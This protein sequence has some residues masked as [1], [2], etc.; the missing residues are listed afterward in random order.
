MAGPIIISASSTA[1]G[2]A[3]PL[4]RRT[5]AK[6]L[7]PAAVYAVT[8]A[9]TDAEA[10]RHLTIG[11]LTDD[12]ADPAAYAGHH[13]YVATGVEAGHQTR[14]LSTGTRGP[15]GLIQLARPTATVVAAGSEIE[16]SAAMP[17]AAYGTWPTLNECVNEAL[18][19]LPL[20]ID[21]DLTWVAAQVRYDLS[22]LA[23]RTFR[24]DDVVDVYRPIASGLT[25]AET[26]A[27][28][29]TRSA[30]SVQYD[31]EAPYLQFRGWGAAGGDTF[32]VRLRRP[33]S[34]WI[35]N[36]GW[37][38]STTG[39]TSDTMAAVYDVD[40]VVNVALPIACGRLERYWQERAERLL[41][42]GDEPGAA[43][44]AKRAARWAER[45]AE[46]GRGSAYARWYR[47][48]RGDGRQRIG[49]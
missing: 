2:V 27:R 12:E 32:F 9:A 4:Y 20:V 5:L 24:R 3:L 36:G 33:A 44:A 13:A 35:N 31:G 46:D 6:R 17:S 39:L 11:S 37:G 16:L 25:A 19:A 10:R 29:I 47:G 42:A 48:Y 8:T 41:D 34:S 18:D 21:H 30:W 38:S 23:W 45:R 28:P 15:L 26:L 40:T 49:A 7:G 43:V 22:D 14:V 1:A